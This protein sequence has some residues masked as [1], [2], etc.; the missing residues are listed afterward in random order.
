M[1]VRSF[2]DQY[3]LPLQ[4][5]ILDKPNLPTINRVNEFSQEWLTQQMRA[6][7]SDKQLALEKEFFEMFGKQP[8]QTRSPGW[9]ICAEGWR[10]LKKK[11]AWLFPL[12]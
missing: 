1:D 8:E 4:Y 11:S 6:L 10:N 3:T 5:F 7:N 2:I 9:S 12:R